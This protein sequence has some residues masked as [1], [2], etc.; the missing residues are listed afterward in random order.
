M[1]IRGVGP[2]SRN[3]LEPDYLR[4]VFGHHACGIVFVGARI[5]NAEHGLA[6]SS[7]T[8]VSL[9]PPLVSFCVQNTS[10]TWPVLQ[11]CP[12]LGISILGSAHA[13][14]VRSLSAKTGD[15]FRDVTTTAGPSG[16]V[17]I[18]GCAIWMETEVE[19]TVPAGDHAIVVL[20]VLAITQNDD[21]PPVIFY[22]SSC[23]ALAEAAVGG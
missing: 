2:A 18:D 13:A 10:S 22:R 8:P 17:F 9:D 11:S 16:A 20:R 15:R 1:E 23:H 21:A 4:E 7:F 19:Q 12:R 14:A 5:D 3:V 6:V